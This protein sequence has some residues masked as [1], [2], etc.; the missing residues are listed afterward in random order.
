MKMTVSGPLAMK[1]PTRF[2]AVDIVNLLGIWGSVQ[3]K[4]M[5]LSSVRGQS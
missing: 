1:L 4:L 2:D 5:G 3:D